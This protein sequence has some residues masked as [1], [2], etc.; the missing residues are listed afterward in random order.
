MDRIFQAVN[1]QVKYGESDISSAHSLS[2][3]SLTSISLS[4]DKYL[5]PSM[6][7]HF[8]YKCRPMNPGTAK[9][10]SIPA[11]NQLPSQ[12]IEASMNFPLDNVASRER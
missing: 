3:A 2:D 4:V 6:S 10:R 9:D 5:E 7:A 12:H 1:S 8:L 11:A